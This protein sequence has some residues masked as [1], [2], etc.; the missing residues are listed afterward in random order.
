[1][2]RR[3]HSSPFGS[4]WIGWGRTLDV[5]GLGDWDK[6]LTKYFVQCDLHYWVVEGG[7]RDTGGQETHAG[8]G[9]HVDLVGP[10][11]VVQRWVLYFSFGQTLRF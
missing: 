5:L 6:G 9:H 1:M 8:A 3:D 4:T 11:V 7:H 2:V 10:D